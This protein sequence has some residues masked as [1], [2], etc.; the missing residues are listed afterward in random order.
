MDESQ[1]NVVSVFSR[2]YCWLLFWFST[3]PL[4]VQFLSRFYFWFHFRLDSSI[5]DDFHFVSK[6]LF[7]AVSLDLMID[8]TKKHGSR[9]WIN[10]SKLRLDHNLLKLDILL[11]QWWMK[12]NLGCRCCNDFVGSKLSWDTYVKSS[13]DII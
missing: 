12:G 8:G 9:W 7:E 6:C 3:L 10:W 13:G 11:E 5:E 1:L 4:E 2:L